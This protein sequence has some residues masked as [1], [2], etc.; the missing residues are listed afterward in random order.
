MQI[1]LI[2][3]G[4]TKDKHLVSLIA[5]YTERIN[6]YGK[7]ENLELPDIRFMA[8]QPKEVLMEKE[9]DLLMK[10]FGPTDKIILLDAGGKQYTSEAFAGFIDQ[11]QINS[12]RNLVFVIGGAFGFHVKLQ[13][14]VSEKCS[15]SK[16]T[17]THQM[18]RLIFCEQLYRAYTILNNEPYHHM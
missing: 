2:S 14:K 18:V 7:F 15:L 17:F 6:R 13:N 9:A 3:I 11:Q 8:N 5:D 4:K 1:K 16:L 10:H 12:T